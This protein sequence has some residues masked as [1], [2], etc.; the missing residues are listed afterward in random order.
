MLESRRLRAGYTI[1]VNWELLFLDDCQSLPGS[2][3]QANEPCHALDPIHHLSPP[4]GLP[5]TLVVTKAELV[6][7]EQRRFSTWQ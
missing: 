7:F 5:H 6:S 1:I 2:H 4:S 3:T